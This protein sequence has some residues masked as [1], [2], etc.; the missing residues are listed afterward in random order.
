MF[1]FTE[2]I[3]CKYLTSG[4]LRAGYVYL[5]NKTFCNFRQILDANRPAATT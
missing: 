3:T 5:E 2:N 1:V 4:V